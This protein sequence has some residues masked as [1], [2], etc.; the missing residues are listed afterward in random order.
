MRP[1][2]FLL[3]VSPYSWLE[4]FTP[5]EAWLGGF[6]RDGQA[7]RA[8]DTLRSMLGDDFEL[9]KEEDVPLVIREH[10]RKFQYIV[11]HAMLW[12]RK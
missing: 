1:G 3:L 7:V 2:G 12:R 8:A 9:V 5:P 11:S 4:Q 10:A 6:E